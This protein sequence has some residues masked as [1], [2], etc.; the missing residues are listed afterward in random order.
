[1]KSLLV[2]VIL[3]FCTGFKGLAQTYTARQLYDEHRKNAYNFENKYRNK[4]ITITGKIRSIAPVTYYWQGYENYH[5]IYLTATG[6]ENYVT[7]QIPYE[8]SSLLK[9]FNAGETITVTGVVAPTI[10]DALY[11]NDCTFGKTS[12]PAA[13]TS[14]APKNIPIGTYHVY[15]NDGTGFNYQY[16]LQLKGYSSYVLNGKPGSCAYNKT[17]KVIRFTS[18]PLKG[19]TGIYRPF[20]ENQ[21]DPPTIVLDVN[22]KVP[23]LQSTARGYQ[24]AYYQAK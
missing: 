13:V 10:V 4:K 14:K 3:S 6:Y 11:L 15:Q 24:Y 18:G 9:A 21:Q 22:G 19:F 2:I 16:K 8:D 5:K 1:M 17:T 20:T 23:D 7:C 12:K